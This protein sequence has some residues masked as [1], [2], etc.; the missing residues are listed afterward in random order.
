MCE[1]YG[2]FIAGEILRVSRTHRML[3]KTD[4]RSHWLPPT[5][6]VL[7]FSGDESEWRITNQIHLANYFTDFLGNAINFA[8]TNGI[9][10]NDHGKEK[11][12][13]QT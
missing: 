8:K 2:K 9:K 4:A 6:Y 3:V 5:A 10:F 12:K 13:D 7:I 1:F 11:S